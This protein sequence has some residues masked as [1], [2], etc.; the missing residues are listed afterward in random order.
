MSETI[1]CFTKAT[2]MQ[3]NR[4]AERRSY[5]RQLDY[6]FLKSLPD[7][8]LFPAFFTMIHEHAQGKK[9]DPHVRCWVAF[10]EKGTKAFIDC[11]MKLYQNLYSVEVP[12]E[13]EAQ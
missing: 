2:I 10:D 1:K 13:E 11:D 6:Q 5:N 9:V 4:I 7:D 8:K 3:A 12:K